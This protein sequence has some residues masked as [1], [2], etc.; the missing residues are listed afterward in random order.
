MKRLIKITLIAL[1]LLHASSCTDYLDIV[2][3]N[4]VTL[5]DYFERRAMAWNALC[6]VYSYLPQDY[7]SHYTSWSLGDEWMGQIEMETS[8]YAIVATR[9]MRGLQNANNPA[10][11]HWTGT[12][13]GRPLY[14]GIRS[15]NTFL[16]YIDMAEDMTEQEIKEWK[17]QVKFLKAYFHFLLLRQYG[18]VVIMDNIVPLDA[19]SEDLFQKRSKV[20]DC[21]DYIIRLMNE[22]IPDI[23]ETVDENELGLLTRSGAVA[24]KARVMLFRA[25]PFFNG[26]A[27]Y[28]GDFFDFD[29]EF[30]VM[31]DLKL[32][33]Q[34]VT[35][36]PTEP[37]VWAPLIWNGVGSAPMGPLTTIVWR[38]YPD[39]DMNGEVRLALNTRWG[40]WIHLDDKP[41]N[42]ATLAGNEPWVRVVFS[43]EYDISGG[44]FRLNSYVNGH[45]A[46]TNS[47][48]L[49]PQD[50]NVAHVELVQGAEV[51]FM[52]RRKG[53]K[54]YKG[55]YDLTTLA[56]WDRVLTLEEVATLGTIGN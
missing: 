17:A 54:P 9:I 31:M 25:S 26:N 24:I 42:P 2:P 46:I 39:E 56:M 30:T 14:Q 4:T 34:E 36:D 32:L 33:Y 48:Y 40:S 53:D 13:G 16:E 12:A 21:F 1:S 18:P 55:Q 45:P 38:N 5:E 20:E 49:Y 7:L 3:D 11:G 15:A 35:D 44:Q 19:L 10:L 28:Y 52:T 27:E 43:Y 37:Q 8:E 50:D 41:Y 6:K 47:T 22:A 29:G 23:G 51:Y